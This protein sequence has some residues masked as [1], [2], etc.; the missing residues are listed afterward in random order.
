MDGFLRS[1]EAPIPTAAAVPEAT[2]RSIP[3]TVRPVLMVSPAASP[4]ITIPSMSISPPLRQGWGDDRMRQ[5]V[6]EDV[7][8]DLLPGGEVVEA[9]DHATRDQVAAPDVGEQPRTPTDQK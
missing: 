4:T 5:K 7:G 3:R 8:G 2:A 6:V 9:Q 1:S